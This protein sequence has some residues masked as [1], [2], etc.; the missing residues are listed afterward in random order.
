MRPL[1]TLQHKHKQKS[2][3]RPSKPSTPTRSPQR[4][5]VCAPFKRAWPWQRVA[6]CAQVSTLAS[7]GWNK[8]VWLCVFGCVFDCVFDLIGKDMYTSTDIH[9]QGTCSAEP[10][11]LTHT[12]THSQNIHQ[13]T[14]TPTLTPTPTPTP[15]TTCTPTLTTTTNRSSSKNQFPLRGLKGRLE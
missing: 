1:R 9:G 15:T 3:K 13:A 6:K 5:K 14:P 11:P 2:P 8:C 10:G 12:N 7:Y 4:K